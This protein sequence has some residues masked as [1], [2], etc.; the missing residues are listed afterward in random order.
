[1]QCD[2]RLPLLENKSDRKDESKML[3]FDNFGMLEMMMLHN[4]KCRD[5]ELQIEV[6][7][8][9]ILWQSMVIL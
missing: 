4:E 7:V 9:P 5:S 6:I 1:M 8:W 2:N 3:C